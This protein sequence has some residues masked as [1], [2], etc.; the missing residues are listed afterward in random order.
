MQCPYCR[1]S[2][3]PREAVAEAEWYDI[4]SLIPE[5]GPYSKL[6]ME[7][8]E[9]FGV[10][11]LRIKSKKL[12]R[13]LRE[14]AVLFR[15]E[16]FKFHKRQYRISRTGIAEALRTVCNK[17]FETPLENHNYLKKVMIGISERE[18]REEGI[19]RE[20]ELRRK[21]ASIMAGVRE[22]SIT[23]DEYKRRAGIE[24]LAA[25]VGKDM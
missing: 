15:N 2:F 24:S 8:C 5:F 13:L 19:R 21:E 17:H 10:T 16:S 23:A 4:I 9:L 6:V 12:L 7:Y 3:D 11:P 22:E 1:K 25:M 18:Q 20:K 14:A